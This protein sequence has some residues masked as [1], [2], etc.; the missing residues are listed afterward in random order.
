[1][2]SIL[3]LAPRSCGQRLRLFNTARFLIVSAPS[4]ESR[5]HFLKEWCAVFLRACSGVSGHGSCSLSLGWGSNLE[6]I[7][8]FRCIYSACACRLFTVV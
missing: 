8:T 6:L 2:T 7:N 4:E 1:M 3:H 5:G